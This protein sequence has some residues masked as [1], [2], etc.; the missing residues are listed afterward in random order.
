M[1]Q[2]LLWTGAIWIKNELNNWT[3]F[4]DNPS[5]VKSAY[6]QCTNVPF[7]GAKI[8]V[9]ILMVYLIFLNLLT[10]KFQQ[11]VGRAQAV[12]ANCVF[13]LYCLFK[14]CASRSLIFLIQEIKTGLSVFLHCLPREYTWASMST[15][16]SVSHLLQVLHLWPFLV[17]IGDASVDPFFFLVCLLQTIGPDIW[18][19]MQIR[20]Y[21]R[22]APVCHHQRSA[23]AYAAES[24]S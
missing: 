7:S 16:A 8:F 19:R 11:E 15:L 2:P 24:A 23:A 14:G 22:L 5:S 21:C 3:G 10:C 9:N 17:L 12:E 1:R 18:R 20:Q 13:Y 4:L 6:C